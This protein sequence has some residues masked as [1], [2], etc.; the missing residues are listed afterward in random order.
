MSAFFVFA[1]SGLDRD[2]Y[3]NIDVGGPQ[4]LSLAGVYPIYDSEQAKIREWG[5]DRFWH[6]PNFDMYDVKRAKVG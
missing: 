5:L 4:K 3:L 6:H 1:P 2:A